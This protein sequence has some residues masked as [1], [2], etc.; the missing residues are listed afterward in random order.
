MGLGFLGV[1]CLGSVFSDFRVSVQC[2]GL[3]VEAQFLGFRTSTSGSV[4]WGLGCRNQGQCLG[5]RVQ[6]GGF[7]G[8]SSSGEALNPKLLNPKP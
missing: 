3:R 4:F 6:E 7:G 1:P 8:F 2:L 5:F